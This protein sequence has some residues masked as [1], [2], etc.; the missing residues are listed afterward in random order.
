MFS[1]FYY[2]RKLKYYK[3]N[4]N[5]NRDFLNIKELKHL[6]VAMECEDFNE[7]RKVEKGIKPLLNGVKLSFI[8]FQNTKKVEELTHA[9]GMNDVLLFRED[10]VRK[11]TPG[12]EVVERIDALNPDVF[13]N[14]CRQPSLVIDFLSDISQAKMRVGFEDKKQT[15]DFMIA[16][17]EKEGYMPFFEK[18]IQV[19]SQINN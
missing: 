3:A 11:L 2:K 8:C 4:R 1:K 14:F 5:V 17:P 19:M 7:M 12:K 16:V 13:V 15:V 9:V 6:V 18:M 10:L